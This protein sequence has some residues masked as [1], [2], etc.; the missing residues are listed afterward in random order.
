MAKQGSAGLAEW[1][2]PSAVGVLNDKAVLKPHF[3]A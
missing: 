3:S 1:L 2:L